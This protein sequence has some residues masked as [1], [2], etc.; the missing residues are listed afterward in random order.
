L[1]IWIS[2]FDIKT[3]AKL[4]NSIIKQK[5]CVTI[6]CYLLDFGLD[7]LKSSVSDQIIVI[8][9]T[10]PARGAIL[11]FPNLTGYKMTRTAA[12]AL[13]DLEGSELGMLT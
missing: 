6:T 7:F 1:A 8:T 3:V 12:E 10:C 11:P 9:L 2:I 13:L 5:S 4:S